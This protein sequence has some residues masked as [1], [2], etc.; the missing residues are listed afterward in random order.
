MGN[1]PSPEKLVAL[2]RLSVAIIQYRK[3]KKMQRLALQEERRLN[4]L[5]GNL[6]ESVI[7]E[8]VERTTQI[9]EESR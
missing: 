5:V 6:P 3:V 1:K 4:I 8:Y 7:D 9:D 2:R